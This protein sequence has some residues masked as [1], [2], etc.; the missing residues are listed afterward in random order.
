MKQIWKKNYMETRPVVQKSRATELSIFAPTICWFSV[1]NW[2]FEV[3]SRIVENLYTPGHKVRAKWFGVR[4]LIR[5]RPLSLL[6]NVQT[7]CGNHSISYSTNAGVPSQGK[8]GWDVILTTYIQLAPKFRM[9]DAISLLLLHAL[10]AWTGNWPFFT[11]YV[12]Y[13]SE[14]KTALLVRYQ[15]S[16][17]FNFS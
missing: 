8:S 1:W 12:T 3:V 17:V 4:M 2:C 11:F 16:T 7:G 14:Y 13:L 9:T 6:Q 10:M 15:P 5:T